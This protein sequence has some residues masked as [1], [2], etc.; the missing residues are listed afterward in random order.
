MP[1]DTGLGGVLL[2]LESFGATGV[3]IADGEMD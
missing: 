3:E 2:S 1:E